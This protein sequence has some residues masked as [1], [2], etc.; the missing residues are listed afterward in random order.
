M[1]VSASPSRGIQ[2]HLAVQG[3]HGALHETSLRAGEGARGES[4]T[5]VDHHVGRAA[6]FN[7]LGSCC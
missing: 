5:H 7:R 2:S 3:R 4:S 1:E 6:S